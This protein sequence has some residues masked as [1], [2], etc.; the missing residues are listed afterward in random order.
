[1]VLKVILDWPETLLTWDILFLL[2]VPWSSPVLAPVLVSIALIG[3]AI[4]ILR[5]EGSPP[6]LSWID[7]LMEIVA[8]TAILAS[9]MWNARLLLSDE[10]PEEFK[11]WLFSLGLIGGLGWFVWRFIFQPTEPDGD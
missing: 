3:S 1:M 6:R 9:F 8:G 11:W 2:P 5:P 10:V 7:W 4:V